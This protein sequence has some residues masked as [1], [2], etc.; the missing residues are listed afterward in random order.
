MTPKKKPFETIMGKGQNDCK[1]IFSF[2]KNVFYP[3]QHKFQFL[4][5]N[6]LSS[7]NAFNLSKIL[8]FGQGISYM[9]LSLR[10]LNIPN[11]NC[12]PTKKKKS[13]HIL[14]FNLHQAILVFINPKK[15]FSDNIVGKGENAF[16]HHFLH[17]L[18]TV[19]YFQNIFTCRLLM[20]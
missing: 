19:F 6:I 13:L 16:N 1:Q 8:S 3:F 5:T 9:W 7:T 2:S 12:K 4:V 17:F 18:S 15:L 11:Q 10:R 20:L 14:I